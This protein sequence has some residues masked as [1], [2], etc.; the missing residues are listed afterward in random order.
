MIEE[1]SN[2]VISPHFRLPD[3]IK[4]LMLTWEYPPQVVGGLAMHVFGLSKQIAQMGVEVHV[5]TSGTEELPSFEMVEDVYVYR[6]QPLNECDD[7]FLSWIGG[8]NWAM[9]LKAIA[10]DSRFHFSMIHAHDWL[11]GA[12]A[13]TLKDWLGISLMTTIHATEYGR[14]SGIH[15]EIQQF[16]HQ[17]EQ[18]L[19]ASSDQI[20]VCSTYMREELI[21]IF[22]ISRETIAV[23]PN[24]VEFE[25]EKGSSKQLFQKRPDQTLIFSVGRI[26]REKGFET[27][28]K[29]AE[30]VKEN[31]I[32]LTFIVAGKGPMLE[33]YRLYVREKQLE[34][35]LKFIGYITDE[36]KHAYLL[37]SD[38]TVFPSLYE[39]FGIVAL[40]SL[41]CGKPTIVSETGGLAGII[42][43]LQTGLFM[44]PGNALSLLE[45][46]QFLLKNPR[47][48][49]EM[50]RQ[51]RQLVRSIYGWGRIAMET[52]QVMVDILFKRYQCEKQTKELQKQTN[53]NGLEN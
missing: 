6:V 53:K 34:E 39:P 16:I 19:I 18:Q 24:G 42:R 35:Q 20:I 22:G 45:Q 38:I 36:E 52:K 25:N 44:E 11:V 7:E 21:S 47:Q 43:H 2:Q 14:N 46:I 5:I 29:A 28:M 37:E 51:G 27:I 30:L 9:V 3:P 15:N 33:N 31:D 8:L 13:V 1:A 40:E 32:N 50:G 17:Q 10:L 12:A 26:V 23:I 4:V 41:A 49:R 48:A